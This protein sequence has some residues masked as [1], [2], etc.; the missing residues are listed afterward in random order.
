LGDVSYVSEGD[1]RIWLSNSA[2]V[3]VPVGYPLFKILQLRLS[4]G[5]PV[6]DIEVTVSPEYHI[7]GYRVR[8]DIIRTPSKKPKIKSS[9]YQAISNYGIF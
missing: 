7:K 6:D 3:P 5:R 8:D 9:D 2:Y 4:N 1:I